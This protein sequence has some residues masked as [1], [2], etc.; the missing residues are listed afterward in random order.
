MSSF[1]YNARPNIVKMDSITWSFCLSHVCKTSYLGEETRPTLCK[2]DAKPRSGDLKQNKHQ[3]LHRIESVQTSLIYNSFIKLALPNL[4]VLFSSTSPDAVGLYV[5][6]ISPFSPISW[7]ISVFR[8]HLFP[9]TFP[10]FL[11]GIS[12]SFC[13]S[14]LLNIQPFFVVGTIKSGFRK[15]AELHFTFVL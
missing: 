1:G 13:Q 2:S 11:W 3:L 10:K 8:S 4:R 5:D 14:E 6:L 15:L 7:K 9:L 12:L